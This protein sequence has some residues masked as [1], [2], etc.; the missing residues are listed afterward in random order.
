MIDKKK[1]EKISEKSRQNHQYSRGP[2]VI[3]HVNGCEMNSLP[4]LNSMIYSNGKKPTSK[5]LFPYI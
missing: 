3:E 4:Y 2:E 1:I 5:I